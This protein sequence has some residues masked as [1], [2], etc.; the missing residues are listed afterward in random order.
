MT[1]TKTPGEFFEKALLNRFKPEKANGIDIIVQ[2]DISGPNGG[3]WTVTVKDQK[4]DSK[5]GIHQ[6]P[7]LS[8]EIAEKDF[9]DIINSRLSGEKAFFTGKIRFKGNIALALKLRDVGF[10]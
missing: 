7:T 1:E 6:S 3:N 5:K 4:I 9:L 10:L 2:V 8:V